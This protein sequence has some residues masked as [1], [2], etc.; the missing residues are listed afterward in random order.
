MID[1]RYHLV[2][3]VS[4]FLALAVGIAL[5]AGP[6]QQPIGRT[7]SSQVATLRQEK[8]DLRT[9]LTAVRRK[10]EADDEFATAVTSQL[11]A[12]KLDGRTVALVTLPGAQSSAVE[13]LSTTLEAAGAKV[14]GV[15]QVE[16]AW[17]EPARRAVRNEL[18]ATVAPSVGADTAAGTA[19][20]DRMAAVLARGLVVSQAAQAGRPT[21][22]AQGALRAL[23]DAGMVT[24]SGDG[25]APANLAVVVS[26]V[27]DSDADP[28]QQQ[29]DVTAW[30]SIGAQLDAAG[31]GAVVSGPI[32]S[33]ASGGVLAAVRGARDV[34]RQVSTV[35]DVATP[36][37]RV[38][39]VYALREQL[40]GRAGQ[41]GAGPGAS[42]V[43]PAAAE[44]R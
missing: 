10:S 18:I 40:G 38:A 21:P 12:T 24:Y 23:K 6:L 27:P 5:G 42:A 34:R 29:S 19:T 1:F 39:V 28:Q 41:Y 15:V 22:A 20:E 31:S 30:A 8:D 36:V 14:S 35:E 16:P 43:L 17:V 25:P 32:E 26:G 9:Q 37:G 33:A 11:V 13:D 2:S 3:I 7:L 4:I 44:V